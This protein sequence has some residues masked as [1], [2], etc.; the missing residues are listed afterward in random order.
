MGCTT[1]SNQTTYSKATKI[2]NGRT[3]AAAGDTGEINQARGF[4]VIDFESTTD[5]A[6]LSTCIDA[7][8]VYMENTSAN[9][10][11]SKKKSHGKS[12]VS[13]LSRRNH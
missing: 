10:K 13:S 9:N 5:G 2:N 7:P 1:S 4:A 8:S 11:D 3:D 6:T 12:S